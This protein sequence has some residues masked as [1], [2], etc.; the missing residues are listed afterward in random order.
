MQVTIIG[1]GI[2][3]LTAALS[4][5]QI[6]VSCRVYDAVPRLEPIGHGINL[7]PNAVRELTALGLGEQLARAGILT[8]ELAFYNRHGQRIWTEPRGRDAGYRWPQISISRGTLHEVLLAAIGERLGP[9]AVVT[10]HRLVGFEQ[11]GDTVLARFADPAGRP[12]GESASDI[13]IGADGIHSAVRAAFYP[14]EKAVFDGYL[15]YRG[16]VEG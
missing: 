14:G 8:A 13:L 6:G 3:G 2:A 11:R 4:L 1:G 15:H 9:Q 7:Q 16:I 12:A 10:G 5:H